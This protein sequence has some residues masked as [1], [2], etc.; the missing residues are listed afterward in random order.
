MNK[1]VLIVLNPGEEGAEN[2]CR[3]VFADGTNFVDYLTSPLGGYWESCEITKLIRPDIDV[4]NYELSL[5]NKYEYSI[6]IFSGHG[7]Y[8]KA[9]QSTMCELKAKNKISSKKFE[10]SIN[11]R[12]I[13]LDCC[14][15][16]SIDKRP[17]INDSLIKSAASLTKLNPTKCRKYYD[18]GIDEC[19]ARN[20]ITYSC[21]I[22]E[23]SQDDSFFGGYYAHALINSANDWRNTVSIEP[24]YYYTYSVAKAHESAYNRVK[25]R[26]NNLQNPQIEKSKTG[27][28]FPFA[29]VAF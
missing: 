8:D 26:T 13:I 22:G 15:V 25:I 17:M 10:N 23:T 24:G 19:I 11:K 20:I 12:L 14:R 29:I 21:A 16:P 18:K 9:S 3:G 6:V 4:I 1:K 27:P 2:Y 7:E 28:Y 5:L